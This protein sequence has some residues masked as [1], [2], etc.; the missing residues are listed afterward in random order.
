MMGTVDILAAFNHH[1]AGKFNATSARLRYDHEAG[2]NMQVLE[3]DGTVNGK[4]F[5]FISDPFAPSISPHVKAREL[6]Q[7]LIESQSTEVLAANPPANPP[8]RP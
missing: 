6:A 1:G 2:A 7:K 3:F 4:P 8:E 5:A